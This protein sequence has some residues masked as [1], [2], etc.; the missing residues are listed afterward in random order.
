M[1]KYVKEEKEDNNMYMIKPVSDVGLELTL[2]GK[3]WKNTH[4]LPVTKAR[5][6]GHYPQLLTCYHH[7][8]S[9]TSSLPCLWTECVSITPVNLQES[10][11]CAQQEAAWMQPRLS[12][13]SRH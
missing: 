5:K 7:E 8:P 13:C 9:G 11:R 12:G 4:Q 10:H 6:L 2:T 3:S 1:E